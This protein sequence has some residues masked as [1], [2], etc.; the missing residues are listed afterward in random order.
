MPEAATK[1]EAKPPAAAGG[2]SKLVPLLLIVNSA[3]LAAVLAL[4]VLKPGGL[5]HAEAAEKPAAAASAEAGSGEQGEKVKDGKAA[6]PGPTMRLPDFVVHLRDVDADRY[7][8]MS[9]ELELPDEKAKEGINARLPQIRDA[10][11]AYLSDR[12]AEELR[13]SEAMVRVKV[14]LSQKLTEVAPA[15][16]VRGLYVTEMVIQ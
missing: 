12:S 13:G 10:F 7:A 2:G 16:T 3:L 8:R 9:F 1:T 5:K 4:L 15:A 11:L 6:L 14:A